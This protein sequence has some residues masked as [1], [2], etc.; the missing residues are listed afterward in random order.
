MSRLY[1]WLAFLFL[2]EIVF[3]CLNYFNFFS[4]HIT[5]I[6]FNNHSLW[7]TLYQSQCQLTQLDAAWGVHFAF[8][9]WSAVESAAKIPKSFCLNS[10]FTQCII[11]TRNQLKYV[12]LQLLSFANDNLYVNIRQRFIS[13]WKSTKIDDKLLHLLSKLCCL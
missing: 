2:F 4:L 6:R 7:I 8:I 5:I 13:Y 10:L 1:R 3:I 11:K 12:V 9:L